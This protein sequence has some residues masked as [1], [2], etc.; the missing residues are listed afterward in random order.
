MKRT[1]LV[2]AAVLAFA[3]PATSWAADRALGF[4]VS[5]VVASV[6][7][8]A[9]DAVKAGDVLARLDPV[10]FQA[11][12]RA[13]DAAVK[14]SKTIFD[15]ADLRYTQTKEL[16]DALSTSAENVEIAETARAQ[17]LMDL[18]SARAAAARAAWALNRASLK[19]P[20]PGTIAATPG[21]PGLVVN[22]Q[23][24]TPTVVVVATE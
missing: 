13:A 6:D 12:K 14:A 1:L 19:A 7:V 4:A 11:D 2:L 18:E 10:P 22:V 3:V 8:K 24:G 9:G 21:Y 5:G 15:L 17:A 23:A 16:F 20:F